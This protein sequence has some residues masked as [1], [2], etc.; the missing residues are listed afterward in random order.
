[1]HLVSPLVRGRTLRAI[2]RVLEEHMSDELMEKMK[3]GTLRGLASAYGFSSTGPEEAHIEETL[4]DDG[5]WSEFPAREDIL[6]SAYIKA[7][8]LALDGRGR[9]P[10]STLWVRGMDNR[11]EATVVDLG[12]RILVVW[13]TPD[14]PGPPNPPDAS[15][16]R[17]VLDSGI[18]AVASGATIQEYAKAFNDRGYVADPRVETYEAWGKASVFDVIFY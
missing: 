7:G 11:F 15:E 17:E 14:P 16:T 3:S 1:M 5:W 10:I 2:D 9:T 4:G 8:E 12:E 6:M 18:Y 13:L